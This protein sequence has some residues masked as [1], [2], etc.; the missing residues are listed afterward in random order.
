MRA[1]GK[2][3]T[4]AGQ[5]ACT[6]EDR[7]ECL[8]L[9]TAGKSTW[10]SRKSTNPPRR[11]RVRGGTQAARCFYD[12]LCLGLPLDG[13]PRIPAAAVA[14]SLFAMAAGNLLRYPGRNDYPQRFLQIPLERTEK[15][16]AFFEMGSRDAGAGKT[17]APGSGFFFP[18]ILFP[19]ISGFS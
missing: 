13:L 16:V 2:Q 8:S 3:E 7:Q 19:V 1:I 6:L 5:G 14:E 11:R 17:P 9:P 4:S 10:Q 18:V 12:P 15:Y